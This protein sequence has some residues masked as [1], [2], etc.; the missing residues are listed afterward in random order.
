VAAAGT[1]YPG[2]V[3]N[4]GTIL[5]WN[6]QS[7]EVDATPIVPTLTAVWGTAPDD[8][9][10]VGDRITLHFNGT[11]WTAVRPEAA[12]LETLYGVWGS[13]STSVWAVGTYGTILYFDGNDWRAESAPG[14]SHLLAVGGNENDVW[15][16]GSDGAIWRR[17]IE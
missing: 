5:R 12:R 9:W 1:F 14:E 10:A 2:Y 4:N 16:V 6:G 17:A 7:W 11:A 8:I 15:A 3:V 13:G